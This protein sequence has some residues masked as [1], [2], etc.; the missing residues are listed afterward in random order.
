MMK[1]MLC[2]VE[3]GAGKLVYRVANES[4]DINLGE[5]RNQ[6]DVLTLG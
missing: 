5:E 1:P 4:V 3:R 2:I 6:Q